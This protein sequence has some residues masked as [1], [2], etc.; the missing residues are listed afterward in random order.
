MLVTY[1]SINILGIST[2]QLYRVFRPHLVQLERRALLSTGAPKVAEA[3]AQQSNVKGDGDGDGEREW[4]KLTR[5]EV[6]A[7]RAERTR[8]RR[9]RNWTKTDYLQRR[10]VY[11]EKISAARKEFS[12]LSKEE[13]EHIARQHALKMEELKQIRSDRSK[14]RR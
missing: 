14:R 10:D 7:R 4:E 2:M 11:D 13:E 3:A 8:L 6:L 9:E 5:E 12:Q 1:S